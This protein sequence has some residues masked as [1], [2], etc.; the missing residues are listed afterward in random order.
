MMSVVKAYQ[1]YRFR[2]KYLYPTRYLRLPLILIVPFLLATLAYAAGTVY[3][4][5]KKDNELEKSR[6]MQLELQYD[7]KER[8]DMI[9]SY[10]QKVLQLERRVEILDA[11]QELSAADVSDTTKKKI[12]KIV[13]ET[14]EKYGHDPFLLLAIMSTESSLQPWAESPVG[15]HGLMQLMP[16]TG[17][18]LSK[19]VEDSPK[20][21]GH[22]RENE[23]AVPQFDEI[24][25]NVELG[26]LYLT[27]L[28]VRYQNLEEAI[29][30]YNLGP[31]LFEKRK[32]EGGPYPRRY[33]SKILTRYAS[34]SKYRKSTNIDQVAL[35]N[36]ADIDT[37]IARAR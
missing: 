17:Q 13:D 15:A 16:S 4:I 12:A 3:W 35:Y 32:K 7:I 29:Y 26:T 2:R 18:Y 9:N 5:V 34:L 21:I 28:L 22:S 10:R 19:Q 1:R 27:Q 37:L 8:D 6:R 36:D 11:I 24:E 25:G 31:G 23:L 14:S 33:L 30:A 20:L